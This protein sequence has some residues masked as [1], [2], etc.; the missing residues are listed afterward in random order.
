MKTFLIGIAVLSLAIFPLS[1][2]AMGAA[3]LTAVVG[4][5]SLAAVSFH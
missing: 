1:A 3:Q 2:V 5:L 4:G